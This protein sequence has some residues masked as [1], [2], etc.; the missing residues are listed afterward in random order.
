MELDSEHVQVQSQNVITVVETDD[1]A[2]SYTI[3]PKCKMLKCSGSIYNIIYSPSIHIISQSQF[4][5]FYMKIT[6][7]ISCVHCHTVGK[8]MF[9]VAY[10]IMSGHRIQQNIC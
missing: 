10:K 3:S 4:A 7:N 8:P 6:L 5:I 2:T 9:S 1:A